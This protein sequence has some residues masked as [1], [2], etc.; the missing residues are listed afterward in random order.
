MPVL[1]ILLMILLAAALG[2][3]LFFAD[4]GPAVVIVALAFL[5]YYF[6]FP[7]FSVEY[8]YTLLNYDMDIDAIYSRSKR[9][10]KLSFDLRTAEVIAPASSG[11]LSSCRVSKVWDFT[12]RRNPDRVYAVVVS[13]GQALVKVLLEPDETTLLHLRQ[14]G[15][16]KFHSI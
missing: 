8:E 7:L 14:W 1:K 9:K 5:L 2:I 6:V 16:S 11:E 10:K 15:G 3:A 4:F 13:N 12:S